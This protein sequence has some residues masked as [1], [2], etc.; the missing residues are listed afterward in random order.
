MA[1]SLATN[2]RLAGNKPRSL[3]AAEQAISRYRKP[4]LSSASILSIRLFFFY[5]FQYRVK[6]QKLIEERPLRETSG[7]QKRIQTAKWRNSGDRNY[8]PS[9]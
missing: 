5:S 9:L 6:P 8:V 1:I 4:R 7:R 3:T 2:L